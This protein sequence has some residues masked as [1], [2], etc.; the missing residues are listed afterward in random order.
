M[1]KI[2]LVSHCMLNTAAKVKSYKKDERAAEEAL[3]REVIKKAIDH[4]I[5]FLQ[6]PCPEYLQYG[7]NRWGH[8]FEQ[9]DNIFFRQ[10]CREML[11]PVIQQL[12]EY[13][14]HPEE[15][16]ILGVLGI[17]GSPSCGVKYTCSADWGGEFSGRD[18]SRVLDSCSLKEAGGVMICV[19]K[20]M[21]EEKNIQLRM[22]GLFAAEPDRA[23]AM[24][25]DSE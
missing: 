12:E 2:L 22:E 4:E 7:Y 8:T 10:R 21:L 23:M 5:Q 17:D 6:L 25:D 11:E 3:R 9:F 20:E 16:E 1:K 19:L 14:V 13:L 24:I 18:V 15:F